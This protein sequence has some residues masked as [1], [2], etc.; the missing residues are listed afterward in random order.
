V[1]ALRSFACPY[2]NIYLNTYILSKN[3]R[4]GAAFFAISAVFVAVMY[5]VPYGI[6]TNVQGWA[7]FAFWTAA[8]FAYLIV[9]A[10][11]MRRMD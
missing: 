10:I 5:A 9:V 3:M 1:N 7:T 6:L 2:D 4:K 8:A 11:F